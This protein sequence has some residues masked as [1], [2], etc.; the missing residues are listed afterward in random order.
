MLR[1]LLEASATSAA[2]HA[3]SS[4]VIVETKSRIAFSRVTDFS[5]F[6]LNSAY[7]A[8]APIT[9]SKPSLSHVNYEH[10]A[11]SGETYGGKRGP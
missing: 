1:R 3:L 6:F 9:S 7:E 8:R 11:E 4:G 2:T 10:A 5:P